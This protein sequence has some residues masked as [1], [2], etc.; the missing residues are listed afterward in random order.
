MK[1]HHAVSIDLKLNLPIA[2]ETVVQYDLA[3]AIFHRGASMCEGH[4]YAVVKGLD[5]LWHKMDDTQVTRISSF[6]SADYTK[7]V[8]MLFYVR[9]SD[10]CG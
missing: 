4:Y 9:R 7:Q 10:T 6:R 1:I 5:G 2:S 3:G 8:Y